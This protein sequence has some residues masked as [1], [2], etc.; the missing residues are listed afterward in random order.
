M[1]IDSHALESALGTDSNVHTPDELYI[2]EAPPRPPPMPTKWMIHREPAAAEVEAMG[3]SNNGGG[4]K[5]QGEKFP[6]YEEL[7]RLPKEIQDTLMDLVTDYFRRKIYPRVVL[8]ARRKQRRQ[9]VQQAAPSTPRVTAA[10]LQL[11]PLFS[12]WSNLEGLIG[13]MRL[14]IYERGDIITHEGDSTQSGIYFLVQGQLQTRVKSPAAN[15]AAN[16]LRQRRSQPQ[17]TI[18]SLAHSKTAAKATLDAPACY[19]DMIYL[20]DEPRVE[21][22]KAVTR[23]AVWVLHKHD[24]FRHLRDLSEERLKQVTDFAYAQRRENILRI[25]PMT[26]AKLQQVP[27][28]AHVPLAQLD[29]LAPKMEPRVFHENQTVCRIGDAG[30]EMFY[31]VRGAVTV[32]VVSDKEPDDDG[33]LHVHLLGEDEDDDGGEQLSP[34]ISRMGPGSVVGEMSVL[35]S[36]KR[37]VQLST[38][39]PS[40]VYALTRDMIISVV[41]NQQHMSMMLEKAHAVM[42][43]R[44][45]HAKGHFIDFIADIPMVKHI[46]PD[47]MLDK[48]LKTFV[49]KVYPMHSTIVSGSE[50]CSKLVIVT[51]GKARLTASSKDLRLGECIGFTCLVPH[52]WQYH[53]VALGTVEC[54]ELGYEAFAGICRQFGVLKEIKLLTLGLLYPRVHPEEF[55]KALLMLKH[56]KNPPC[57]PSSSDADPRPFAARVT[58]EPSISRN[59]AKRGPRNETGVFRSEPVLLQPLATVRPVSLLDDDDT[60]FDSDLSTVQKHR[61]ASAANDDTAAAS[62]SPP[63]TRQQQK[64]K[65]RLTP[66]PVSQTTS[67]QKQKRADEIDRLSRRIRE[68]KLAAVCPSPKKGKGKAAA[69]PEKKKKEGKTVETQTTKSYLMTRSRLAEARTEGAT[70]ADAE[71]E[72]PAQAMRL[73]LTTGGGD[74]DHAHSQLIA[75]V[76]EDGDPLDL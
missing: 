9:A 58:E 74:D 66:L 76:L 8:L 55:Q 28:F 49:T 53:V 19:G 1:T 45:Q 68:L 65:P 15:A 59:L 12:K 5:P 31:V 18:K 10:F 73:L 42:A 25:F 27:M 3:A 46:G 44:Q 72:A 36:Q 70:E 11:I 26:G 64:T 30:T 56:C 40:D 67:Q 23:S 52:R 17:M 57:F 43:Q 35:F 71:A 32:S 41:P 34:V 75:S 14:E 50:C 48:L 33:E 60:D 20:T 4:S 24:F 38:D 61:R 2:T 29:A 47:A 16:K 7:C 21:S 37:N 13:C 69:S 63:H 39:V 51:R 62:A 6:S 54:I 22:L